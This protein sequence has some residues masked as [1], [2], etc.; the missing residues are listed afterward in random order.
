LPRAVAESVRDTGGTAGPT[1]GRAGRVTR[2]LLGYGILAGPF[3]VIVVLGQALTRPGFDLAKDDASLLSN[4]ILGWI[5]VTNFLLTGLMVV[6]CAVGVRRALAHGR[7]AVLGSVLLALYGVGLIGAGLFI[8]D[9][10]NGFPPGARAG[11]PETISTHGLLHIASAGIAF[12]CLVAACFVLARRFAAEGRR[13]WTR[14]SIATGAIFLAAF[15]GV[16]SGSS[17]PVAV[18]AFWF[19]LIVVWAWIGSLSRHFY[20]MVDC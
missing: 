17:S 3:Y 2:S 8:A 11:R 9:P 18:G 1:P 4:G 15:A 12:L 16:A 10:M 20:V 19:G 6:A 13:G 14:F 7:G 5:Q